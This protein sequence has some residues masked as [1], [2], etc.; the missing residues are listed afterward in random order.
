MCEHAVSGRRISTHLYVPA[1]INLL[2]PRDSGGLNAKELA[3]LELSTTV[4]TPLTDLK[5]RRLTL[6]SAMA[7]V[8]LICSPSF[9]ASPG[10]AGGRRKASSSTSIALN[11]YTSYGPPRL[12][13]VRAT[14]RMDSKSVV[15]TYKFNDSMCSQS[16][17]GHE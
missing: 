8:S 16:M 17:S 1:V 5:L 6:Y 13:T 15:P 4:R 2:V 3:A 7:C 12:F 10:G 9:S 11:Q 14:G